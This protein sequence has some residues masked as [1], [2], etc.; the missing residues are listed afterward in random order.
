[1]SGPGKG[2]IL[3]AAE[4]D[5]TKRTLFVA[6]AALIAGGFGILGSTVRPF[7]HGE[8]SQTGGALTASHDA[9]VLVAPPR[10]P[11][12]IQRRSPATV[13][14]QLETREALGVL[15][16][17]V[18][19]S[20][21]TFNGTVPGPFVR[22]RVGDTVHVTLRNARDSANPHS[23]NLHA[24]TGPGGGGE[25]QVAPGGEQSFEWRALNPG[26]FV[27]HCM[28]PHVPVHIAQG[29]YGLIL[30]EPERGLP[31]VDREYYLMQGE[32]YTKGSTLAPGI[33]RFDSVKAHAE[34]PEYVVFNG[35][36][37]ALLDHGAL[38][39]RTGDV[40]RLFV[41]NGGPS[42]SSYFHAVGAVFDTVYEHGAIGGVPVRNSQMTTIPPG[43]SAIVEFKI[44]VPGRYFLV[45]HNYFRGH[46]KGTIALLNVEGPE[47]PSIFRA[48]SGSEHTAAHH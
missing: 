9:L 1:L 46:E 21:W 23:I 7:S 40:I 26:L 4:G 10:V 38:Q 35:R 14:V 22:V 44:P 12:P 43:S 19:Y 47:A 41:G 34:R 6:I 33:Q 5:M 37:D 45:D 31:R 42:L 29:M 27:Y 20:F 30:V 28:T 11:P 25:F 8:P 17:G 36:M 18:Q 24:V 32:F 48:H 3:R 2:D 39:A 15:A 16:S 13:S